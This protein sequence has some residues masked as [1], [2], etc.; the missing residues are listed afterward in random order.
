[1]IF[2]FFFFYIVPFTGLIGYPAVLVQCS[3][4]ETP[5]SEL[6]RYVYVNSGSINSDQKGRLM[7]VLKYDESPRESVFSIRPLRRINLY[8]IV[9]HIITIIRF[10]F[11]NRQKFI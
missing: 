9:V 8:R 3:V 10:A 2:S 5:V 7:T 11:K 4:S 1:M 6:Q